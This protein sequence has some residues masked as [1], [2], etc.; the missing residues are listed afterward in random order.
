MGMFDYWSWQNKY[1]H[2][3]PSG[4]GRV[5]NKGAQLKLLSEVKKT[6]F[7][8]TR[9]EAGIN[10]KE[11]KE[12]RKLIFPPKFKKLYKTVESDFEINFD[13]K[14]QT[15]VWSGQRRVWL[16]QICSGIVH[17]ELV[18]HFKINE[19][20]YLLNTELIDQQVV[21]WFQYNSEIFAVED[22]LTKSKISCCSITGDKHLAE[23]QKILNLFRNGSI[24]VLLLQQAVA[25][26]GMNLSCADTAIYFS[27]PD[28][29]LGYKQT[30][31]RIVSIQKAGVLLLYLIVKDTIEED[32]YMGMVVQNLRSQKELDY[33]LMERFSV[34]MGI[35]NG[36]AKM[37]CTG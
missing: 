27:L 24:R 22:L 11:I 26:T 21:V 29:L 32:L 17:G 10:V 37:D 9:K 13:G 36:N 23:R 35:N 34:R 25:Q 20:L 15:T 18:E 3:H 12:I 8:L 19:L 2:L 5:L 6:A 31:D 14:V 7:T 33:L 1:T 16:R 28:G 4:F 30:K